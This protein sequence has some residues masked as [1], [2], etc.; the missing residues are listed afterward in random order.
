M[1]SLWSQANLSLIKHWSLQTESWGTV[2]KKSQVKTRFGKVQDFNKTKHCSHNNL[3]QNLLKL[4][5]KSPS[6]V[7]RNLT[8]ATWCKS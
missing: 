6:D 1:R 8:S 5:L 7:S 4:S 3:S 2:L